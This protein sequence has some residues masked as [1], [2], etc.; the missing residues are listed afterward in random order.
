[1]PQVV[2]GEHVH[3]TRDVL[4][5]LSECFYQSDNLEKLFGGLFWVQNNYQQ[6]LFHCAQ[7]TV[8]HHLVVFLAPLHRVALR[9]GLRCLLT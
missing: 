4:V 9:R 8:L 3:Q 2:V 6:L 7:H 1:M 5:L